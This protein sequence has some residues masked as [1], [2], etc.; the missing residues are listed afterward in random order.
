MTP[1]FNEQPK[2]EAPDG[3]SAPSAAENQRSVTA[4]TSGAG[5]SP[6][7]GAT[8]TRSSTSTANDS[9]QSLQ[10]PGGGRECTCVRRYGHDQVVADPC[11][12]HPVQTIMGNIM[13]SSAMRQSSAIHAPGWYEETLVFRLDE[14]GKHMIDQCSHHF[15][16]VRK[17]FG[18]DIAVYEA[19]WREVSDRQGRIHA[20]DV[21]DALNIDHNEGDDD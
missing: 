20:T 11:T 15:E 13:V 12:I 9:Q 4:K 21:A 14:N 5:T 1:A 16:A 8:G 6:A 2:S 19:G 17:W 3:D 7:D 10:A 18:G